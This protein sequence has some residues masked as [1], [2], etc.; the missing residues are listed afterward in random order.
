MMPTRILHLHSPF[1]PL[2]IPFKIPRAAGGLPPNFA[3]KTQH[4]YQY[5]PIKVAHLFLNLVMR[6]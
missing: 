5:S 3:V 6:L 4:I 2:L 1:C